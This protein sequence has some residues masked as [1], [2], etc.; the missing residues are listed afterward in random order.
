[1]YVPNVCYC[2][3]DSLVT[4]SP[5]SQSFI[6][7][8]KQKVLVYT[9]SLWNLKSNYTKIATSQKITGTT[10]FNNLIKKQYAQLHYPFRCDKAAAQFL[11]SK[12]QGVK[13][14][15]TMDCFWIVQSNTPQLGCIYFQ[16]RSYYDN[17]AQFQ[18]P[19]IPRKP[20]FNLIR[21]P[22]S[23]IFKCHPTWTLNYTWQDSQLNDGTF[24]EMFYQK[25]QNRRL[26]ILK[27]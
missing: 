5:T 18:F 25:T 9:E 21:K 20:N 8:G 19:Q 6:N 11:T 2:C 10:C 27:I 4:A 26:Q 22:R 12:E 1:M 15:Q 16:V 14:H 24:L 3:F 13:D 7:G 17:Q 23:T